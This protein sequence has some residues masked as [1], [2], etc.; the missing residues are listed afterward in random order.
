MKKNLML[1]AVPAAAFAAPCAAEFKDDASALAA[2]GASTAKERLSAIYYFGSQRTPG[3]YEALTA[4]YPEE[5][6]AYLRVQIVE[7]LDVQGSTWAYSCAVTAAEDRNKAVRQAAAVSLSSKAGDPVADRKLKALAAD[8]YDSVRLSLLSALSV[9]TST[10]SV[11]II[12]A[13]LSDHKGAAGTRR[14]AANILSK[15][16]TKASDDMLLRYLSDSD[17]Q[18]K[19]AAMA[20]RPSGATP[21][22]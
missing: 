10:S 20:R 8:P 17:P 1:C 14:A 6:D 21:D 5:K 22:K 9:N 16:K 18:I 19:A 7:A 2:L 3:A 11:S 15:M 12:G 4:H 13:V